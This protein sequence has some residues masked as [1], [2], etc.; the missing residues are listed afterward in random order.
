MIELRDMIFKSLNV[1]MA[2]YNSSCFSNFLEFLE[3]CSFVT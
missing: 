3:L 2:S 1:S